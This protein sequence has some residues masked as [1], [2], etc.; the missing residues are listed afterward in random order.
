MQ[1]E[2]ATKNDCVYI[3]FIYNKNEVIF[4]MNYVSLIVDLKKSRTYKVSNRIEIQE[5]LLDCTDILNMIFAAE[6]EFNVT[7]SAGD[8]LQGLF[9]N[10]TAAY[11]YFRLLSMLVHPVQIRA[12]IGVGEWTIKIEQGTSTQ[13]DGP[14]YHKARQAIEEVY[15]MQLQNIRICADED[16][17]LGNYFINASNA[18]KIQQISKQH[19]VW[20][21]MEF[22]Y[23]FM[24]GRMYE[25]EMYYSMKRLFERKYVYE[26]RRESKQT[27]YLNKYIT[28]RNNISWYND[29]KLNLNNFEIVDPIDIDGILVEPESKILKR[30]VSSVISELLGCSRQNVDGLIRRGNSNKIR[31]LDYVALQYLE[32]KYGKDRWD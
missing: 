32:R 11:L 27:R 7:F 9:K 23:P 31:E 14:A 3:V 12:G 21:I 1:I 28:P 20:V 17:I 29:W 24:S 19:M 26:F 22:L 2:N 13:Q 5:F 4:I 30:N 8:E 16:D 10:V 18:L 6:I 25:R 15:K